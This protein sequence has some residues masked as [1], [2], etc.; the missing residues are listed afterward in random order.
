MICTPRLE[1]SVTPD[2]GVVSH[3]D[4]GVTPSVF[5][6]AGVPRNCMVLPG[7]MGLPVNWC[8]MQHGTNSGDRRRRCIRAMI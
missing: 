1:S 5:A 3:A 6:L 8:D 2:D 4:V 7:R